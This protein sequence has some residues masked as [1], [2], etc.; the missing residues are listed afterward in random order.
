V[1]LSGEKRGIKG[2]RF[3]LEFELV[4]IEVRVLARRWSER[5]WKWKWSKG[6]R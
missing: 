1:F 4:R 5:V 2:R 3:E 6:T